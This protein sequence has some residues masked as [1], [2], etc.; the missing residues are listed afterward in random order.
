MYGTPSFVLEVLRHFAGAITPDFSTYQDFPE[1]L[2]I[3]NT[4]R[5][6]VYGYWLGKD[7]IAVYNNARWGTPETWCYCYDGLPNDSVICVGLRK[8]AGEMSKGGSGLFNGTK[9]ASANVWNDIMPTA[10]NYPGTELPRSFI[11]KTD[12][13]SYDAVIHALLKK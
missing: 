12:G 7:G 2:K 8:E 10:P 3:Y 13:E 1:P 6:R 4:Y 11:I 5:M 9:G